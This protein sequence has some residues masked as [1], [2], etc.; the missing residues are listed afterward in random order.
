MRRGLALDPK[1]KRGWANVELIAKATQ[2]Q[3]DARRTRLRLQ[4]LATLPPSLVAPAEPAT[5]QSPEPQGAGRGRG[6]ATQAQEVAAATVEATRSVATEPAGRGCRCKEGGGV[7][8]VAAQC[9]EA[10]VQVA[11]RPGNTRAFAGEYR[12]KEW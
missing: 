6:F 11:V 8:V 9:P 10:V 3:Y 12:K 1:M 4:Q 5:I 7:S 2:P